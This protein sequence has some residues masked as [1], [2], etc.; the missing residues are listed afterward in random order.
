MAEVANS[1]APEIPIKRPKRVQD[2]K[3]RNGKIKIQ[4]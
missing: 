1:A 4:R 3:L 2:K